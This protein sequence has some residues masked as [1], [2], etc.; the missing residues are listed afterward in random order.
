MSLGQVAVP[1]LNMTNEKKY[2]DIKGYDPHATALIG[3]FLKNPGMAFVDGSIVEK[4]Q[5]GWILSEDTVS[6]CLR[7]PLQDHILE[8]NKHIAT[9]TLTMVQVA[10]NMVRVIAQ[11]QQYMLVW[12]GSPIDALSYFRDN[13]FPSQDTLRLRG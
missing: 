13:H 9:F 3:C 12:Q 2:E 6:S 1:L 7:E 8:R 5:D 10:K 11:S 4:A